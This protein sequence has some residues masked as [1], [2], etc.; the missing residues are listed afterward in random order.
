MDLY[1]LEAAYP[2]VKKLKRTNKKQPLI[3][4]PYSMAYHFTSHH[5]AIKNL[6]GFKNAIEV[7][8][9]QGH[10][11]LKGSLQRE[12]SK[13]TRAGSTDPYVRTSWLCLD[14]D[15]FADER[16]LDL[17]LEELGLDDVSYII[18][19][20]SKH[21]IKKKFAA[22]LYFMLDHP[23][24]PNQLKLWLTHCNLTISLLSKHISLT[25]TAAAL[26]WPLDISLAQN[27]KLIYI[28]PPICVGFKDPVEERLRVVEKQYD[29]VDMT[30]Q[31]EELDSTVVNQL[32]NDK[33]NELRK[34]KGLKK[35]TFTYKTGPGNIEVLSKP[36]EVEITG[37]REQRGFVYFNLNGGDSWGYFHPVNNAEVIRNFKGEPLYLTKELL[38]SYYNA[39]KKAEIK[40]RQG[41]VGETQFF[42]FLDRRMDRYYRGSYD[43]KDDSLDIYPTDSL[44][45]VQDFMKQNGQPP[46]DPVLEWDY[47]FRFEDDRVFVPEE[48]FVNQ[49]Q[50]TP[51]L[52]K[53]RDSKVSRFPPT[54]LKVLRSVTGGNMDTF[55]HL[56]NWMAAIVQKRQRT[57][58]MW[59][60]HG[61]PGTGKGVLVHNILGPLLGSEYVQV[62]TLSSL[63]E[64]YNHYMEKT[65]ILMIDESKRTQTRNIEKV[66]A[67]LKQATTDPVIP[68]RKMRADPYMA[69]N[70]MNIIV[71]SNYEDPI[72][73]EAGDRR[74][75]VAEYQTERLYLDADDIKRIKTEL[76][77]FASVLMQVSVDE[78][79]AKTPLQNKAREKLMYLTQNSLQLMFSAIVK[80]DLEFFI[81]LLPSEL[82]NSSDINLMMARDAYMKVLQEAEHHAINGTTHKISREQ[83]QTLA[84]YVLNDMPKSA[85]KFSSLAKH[86][87]VQFKRI[88]KDGKKIQGML[89]DWIEPT[90]RIS[91]IIERQPLKAVK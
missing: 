7:H 60:F 70:Y 50:R 23:V 52:K 51:Y 85:H 80:G 78:E 90:I 11:L 39:V 41:N 44:K 20:S 83:I 36:G 87:G 27:D 4:Q 58:T 2:L 14:L 57:Q 26:R 9:S 19:Y 32:K 46:P 28:A 1:F 59:V 15:H 18:Q 30:S 53:A 72:Q 29:T 47:I 68:I 43:P 16:Q 71:A 40:T 24:L 37:K 55:K 77:D 13:E 6:Q 49:Y 67:R 62:K 3:E 56:V 69:K 82:Q 25:R 33:L 21:R 91:D 81:D 79:K 73:L 10:A 42:A 76:Q 12:L 74:I 35:R 61:V 34:E 45:K 64:E 84:Q 63:E 65:L 22:H 31:L 86:H 88:S 38:P 66:M 8:A 89:V 17:L 5:H 75:N 48:K 54:I